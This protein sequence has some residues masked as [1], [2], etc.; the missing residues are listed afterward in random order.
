MV[1]SIFEVFEIHNE[2]LTL[3]LNFQFLIKFF[4]GIW[5]R[6]NF[7]FA[8]GQSWFH[9][10]TR[11]NLRNKPGFLK[12]SFYILSLCPFDA[13]VTKCAVW[14]IL[15]HLLAKC[16]LYNNISKPQQKIK[17]PLTKCIPKN[18]T[19]ECVEIWIISKFSV[20]CSKTNLTSLPCGIRIKQ[21]IQ[22]VWFLSKSSL[23]SKVKCWRRDEEYEQN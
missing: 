12:L 16:T 23:P 19:F 11:R 18:L 21:E 5:M 6:A 15:S 2:K 8:K 13:E 3:W 17:V 22:Q 14:G 20:G 1:L 7:S 10:E 9:H 4:K